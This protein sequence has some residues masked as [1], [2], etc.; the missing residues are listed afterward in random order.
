M[1]TF[2]AACSSPPTL[3]RLCG[4]RRCDGPQRAR[5]HVVLKHYRPH[6]QDSLLTRPPLL[7]QHQQHSSWQAPAWFLLRLLIARY[8]HHQHVAEAV[9]LELSMVQ[10]IVWS[11]A[12]VA[13]THKLFPTRFPASRLPAQAVSCLTTAAACRPTWYIHFQMQGGPIAHEPSPSE[14]TRNPSFVPL[15]HSDGSHPARLEAQASHARPRR[16]PPPRGF[17]GLAQ[18]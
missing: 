9:D 17:R 4:V 8:R 3:G 7:G 14:G 6:H 11:K 13:V 10:G 16:S 2:Q 5:L 1:T 12:T 15:A 18:L